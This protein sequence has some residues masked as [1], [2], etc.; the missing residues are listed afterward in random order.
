MTRLIFVRHGESRANEL[1]TIAGHTD[2]PLTALGLEQAIQTAD[3]LSIEQIDAVYSSDLSRAMETARPHAERRGL[4]VI[5]STAL[6]ELYCGDWEGCRMDDLREREPHRYGVEFCT[7]FLTV[8]IP[9][10]ESIPDCARRFGAEVIRIAKAHEGQTVLIASH[11]GTIRIFWAMISGVP[12]EQANDKFPFPSNSSFSVA[13][14]DGEHF[15]PV[16]YSHDSHLTNVTH[17]HI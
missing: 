11:G 16:E 12:L 1:R 2:Y 9:G 5:P 6:R 10:G 8:E 3:Y 15:T 4:S 7:R 13:E 17:V 14:F